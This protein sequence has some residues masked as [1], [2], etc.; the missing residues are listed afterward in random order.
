MENDFSAGCNTFWGNW[1]KMINSSLTSPSAN[2]LTQVL[3]TGVTGHIATFPEGVGDGA[4]FGLTGLIRNAAVPG[5]DC[6]IQK[7]GFYYGGVVTGIVAT[8][9][10]SGGTAD[11]A[12]AGVASEEA[13]NEG[14]YV[15]S[16]ERGTHVGQSGRIT[17]RLAQHVVSGSSHRQRS[18]LQNELLCPAAKPLERS[19][20]N[21][22]LMSWEGSTT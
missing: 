16:A 14:I 5:A 12:E 20:S 8:T 18:T 21:G 6:Y 11:A 19:Q 4:S 7:D 1:E 13:T 10:V 22:R 3:T 2:T 9:V 15:V 17:Q